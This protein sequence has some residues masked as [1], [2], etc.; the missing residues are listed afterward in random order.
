MLH[1]SP[2]WSRTTVTLL[3]SHSSVAASC[4]TMVSTAAARGAGVAGHLDG[5]S[6]G[7]AELHGHGAALGDGRGAGHVHRPHLALLPRPLRAPRLLRAAARRRVLGVG[8]LRVG[9][10]LLDGALLLVEGELNAELGQLGVAAPPLGDGAALG[11]VLLHLVL[12]LPGDALRLLVGGALHLPGPAPAP[13]AV[14]HQGAGADP[15]RAAAGRLVVVNEAVLS[16]QC[17]LWL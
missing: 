4:S 10:E 9:A 14:L 8:V 11:P 17:E 7:A 1:C 2:G 13:A 12:L 15:Y 5:T 16:R 6:G 3:S